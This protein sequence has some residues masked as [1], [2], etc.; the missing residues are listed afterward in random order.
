MPAQKRVMGVQQALEM[1]HSA[2]TRNKLNMP[3]RLSIRKQLGAQE[4]SRAH[5]GLENSM[6]DVAVQ[7]SLPL[8]AVRSMAGGTKPATWMHRYIADR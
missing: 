3:E 7:S 6:Y 8:L 2:R 1:G 5:F 4:S